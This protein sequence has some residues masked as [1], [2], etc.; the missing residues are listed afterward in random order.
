MMLILLSPSIRPPVADT[1]D[2]S[3]K[4]Q[5]DRCRDRDDSSGRKNKK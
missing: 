4:D 3:S 5:N 1:Q 2:D